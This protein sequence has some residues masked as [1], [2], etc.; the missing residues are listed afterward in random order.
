MSREDLI[1]L[2]M[3]AVID[4][5]EDA[6]EAV[7]EAVIAQGADPL[8]VIAE[9][10]TRGMAKVGE[11]FAAE[12]LSLPEVIAAADAMQLGMGRLEAHIPGDKRADPLGT[13]ILGVSEGDM[14]DIGKRIVATMLSV[15]GFQVVDIGR[16]VPAQR[17]VEE[18]IAHGADIVGCSALMTSTMVNMQG[19][20]D[21]LRAAG[22]REAVR[23]MI[24][25][26]ATTQHWADKIG[27]DAYAEN[28]NE[29]VVVARELMAGRSIN[30][31]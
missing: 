31:D 24:G 13:V 27:A 1:A 26:A 20:E 30:A 17:F 2:A 29:A 19:L 16:D 10:F 12:E 3:Q 6:A 21:A 5:D 28:A 18:A 8:V 7:A 14:H 11:R 15:N 9:G 4:G 23:T 22:L 25:G